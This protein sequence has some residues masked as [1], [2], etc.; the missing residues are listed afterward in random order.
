MLNTLTLQRIR[1][2]SL[3]YFYPSGIRKH[4]HQDNGRDRPRWHQL[5]IRRPRRCEVLIAPELGQLG[6]KPADIPVERPTKFDFILNLSTAKALGL[7]VPPTLLALAD[8]V[9]E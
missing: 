4:Q 3:N 9:I 1:N 5:Q 2:C 8:E 6:A 7:T